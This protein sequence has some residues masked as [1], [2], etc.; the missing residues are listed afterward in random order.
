MLPRMG[1]FFSDLFHFA[2]AILSYWQAYLTGG[3]I[4]GVIG[5]VERLSHYRLTKRGY[6]G[7]FV[8]TF[9]LVSFFSAWRDER[10]NVEEVNKKIADIE[11]QSK[12]D[13]EKADKKIAELEA[14][15]KKD[16]PNLVGEITFPPITSIYT[17]KDG[18]TSPL[19]ILLLSIENNGA[20]TTVVGGFPLQIKGK[21]IDMTVWPVALLGK[22]PY[23]A[24]QSTAAGELNFEDSMLKKSERAIDK[25]DE[26]LKGWLTYIV[27]EKTLDQISIPG[28]ELIVSFQDRLNKA[29]TAKAVIGINTEPPHQYYQP[30]VNIPFRPPEAKKRH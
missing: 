21:T 13:S 11:A 4:T 9:L 29:Y 12:K 27:D 22:T 20:K 1:D 24:S 30:G 19:I 7:V 25:G 3:L 5:M 17:Y 26:A 23:R 14:I 6:V 10:G 16:A 2:I 8:V 18:R 15:I 28:T